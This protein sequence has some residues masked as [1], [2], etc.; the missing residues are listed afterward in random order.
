MWN[1]FIGRHVRR[2]NRNLLIVNLLILVGIGF[3]VAMSWNY[4]TSYF[5][6]PQ[7]LGGTEAASLRY[8]GNSGRVVHIAGQDAFRSGYQYLK[9]NTVM[10]EFLILDTGSTFILVKAPAKDVG[11]KAFMGAIQTP[12][13]GIIPD[14]TEQLRSMY[15][16]RQV[17]FADYMLNAFDY[18]ADAWL[19][20]IFGIPLLGLSLWNLNTWRRRNSDMNAHPAIKA[21]KAAGQP[22][23]VA[24]A[25][26]GE[27][28]TAQDIGKLKLT[29]NWVLFP[30]FF[31]LH[32]RR[33]QDLAW[34]YM[35]VTKHSVNFIPTGKTYAVSVNSVDGSTVDL[36]A[37]NE[38]QAEE[39]VLAI[40]QRAPQAIIGHSPDL[41]NL[42]GKQR[43]EFLAAVEQR[44]QQAG[45]AAAAGA[46]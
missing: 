24:Q 18:D 39:M 2:S 29:P 15:P 3:A 28:P 30:Y 11:Q 32:V 33:T 45:K 41:E 44:R 35:K 46:S 26:E 12:E 20:F 25:I 14:V 38:K 17:V 34:V 13:G 10:A 36:N 31:G 37:K 22:W 9:N 19:G 16:D 1:N 8:A 4:L 7:Q 27:I 42:W 40:A 5:G 43:P 21:L 6:T 23:Q